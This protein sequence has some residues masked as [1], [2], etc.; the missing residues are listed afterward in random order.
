MTDRALFDLAVKAMDN[1]Y[2]PYSHFP[3]GAALRFDDGAVVTGANVENASYGLSLCAETV[4]LTKG[5]ELRIEMSDPMAAQEVFAARRID[6]LVNN[7]GTIRRSKALDVT[8]KD[9]DDVMDLNLK[10][11]FFTAYFFGGT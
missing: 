9:W 1:A 2:A 5:E 6:I 11:V 7:A 10:S 4:A 3:V 8:E